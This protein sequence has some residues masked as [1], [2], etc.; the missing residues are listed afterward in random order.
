MAKQAD[1][2]IQVNASINASGLAFA[3]FGIAMLFAKADEVDADKFPLDTYRTF[4]SVQEV[5]GMFPETTETYKAASKW[6]GGTPKISQIY[7]YATDGDDATFTATL[8]KARNRVWWYSTF[9]TAD[10]YAD[11]DKVKVIADWCEQNASFFPNC[12]TGTNCAAIRDENV[13]NDIASQLTALGYRHCETFP[14]ATD[15]YAGIAYLKHFA[16][17]NYLAENSTITGEFKKSPGVVAEDLLG[18]EMAA[19]E[20]PSKK[21]TYY[22]VVELQGS[23]DN[24]RWLNTITH[25]TYGEY[26]DDVWN[27]DAFINTLTVRLYNALGRGKKLPQDP[28]GFSVLLNTARQVCIQYIRNRYLGPRTYI[29]PD[30]GEEK[31]TEGFEILSQP[32]DILNITDEERADRLAAPIRIRLFR[33]GAIHKAIVDLEIF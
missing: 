2:I 29:D 21:A 32:E 11:L 6:L 14:H 22:S 17:V 5:A 16:R 33:A 28:A 1:Q 15:P 30:D 20:K 3:N 24:G 23:V 7:I 10:V 9:V 31:Y 26:T 18:T 19:M 8:N 12:Q 25:S 4:Q 13:T 27:L